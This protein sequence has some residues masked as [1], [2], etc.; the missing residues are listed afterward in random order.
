MRESPDQ[1]GVAKVEAAV[2][3]RGG[4]LRAR[5]KK[6]DQSSN[7]FNEPCVALGV[8]A[9]AGKGFLQNELVKRNADASTREALLVRMDRVHDKMSSICAAE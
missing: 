5:Y 6:V 1:A 9:K 8:R 4:A 3:A 2:E 7:A